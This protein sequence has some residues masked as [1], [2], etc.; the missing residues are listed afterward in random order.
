MFIT[1]P[2]FLPQ[3]RNQRQQVLQ[4]IGVAEARGQQRLA[5][6]NRGVLTNLNQIIDAL[7]DETRSNPK[8]V[9]DAS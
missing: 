7:D 9:H 6:M 3:H 8:A 1:T 2:E 5:E 4:I